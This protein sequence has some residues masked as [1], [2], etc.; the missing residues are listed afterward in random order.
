M[1]IVGASIM[2]TDPGFAMTESSHLNTFVESPVSVFEAHSK[3]V[4]VES[5]RFHPFR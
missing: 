3:V 1:Y 4:N 2:S 5:L